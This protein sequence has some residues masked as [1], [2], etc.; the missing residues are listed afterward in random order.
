MTN[1]QECYGKLLPSIESAEPNVDH[2]GKVLSFRI[3]RK[4]M[5]VPPRRITEVDLTQWDECKHCA[6]FENCYQLSMARLQLEQAIHSY[7]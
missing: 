4:E 2:K 7:S 6:E 5:L 1:H 3:E